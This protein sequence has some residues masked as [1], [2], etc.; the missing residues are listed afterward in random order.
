MG[1]ITPG[2]VCAH[3]HLYS[4][5]ARGMPAPPSAPHDFLSV[6][7]QIWW[8]LDAAMDLDMLA[9][10]AR[11]C[12]AEAA[13]SGTTAI[14]HNSRAARLWEI[15][16]LWDDCRAIQVSKGSRGSQSEHVGL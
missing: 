14:D 12:A 4:G 6:L 7:Q 5:L 15:D 2:L 11:L 13:M 9:A 1:S 10:A 8:R 3:H 16:N